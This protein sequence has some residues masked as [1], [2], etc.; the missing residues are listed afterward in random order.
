MEPGRGRELV[1]VGAEFGASE[2]LQRVY[3]A[4]KGSFLL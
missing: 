2:T 1:V 3:R 4:S